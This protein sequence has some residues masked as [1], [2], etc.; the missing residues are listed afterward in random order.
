MCAG[1]STDFLYGYSSALGLAFQICDDIL[2]VEGDEAVLGKPV[3]SDERNEKTTFIKLYGIGG[4]KMR[5]Q[6][7]TQSAIDALTVL[8]DNGDFL[9]QLALYLLNREN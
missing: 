6:E 9:E 5:L 7:E 4:A 8:G 3:N 1:K 2:D